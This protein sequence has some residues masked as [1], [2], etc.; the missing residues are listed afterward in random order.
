MKSLIEGENNN[1]IDNVD[2][3]EAE[4]SAFDL[5]NQPPTS[6]CT[7][8]SSSISVKT[9]LDNVNQLK[10]MFPGRLSKDIENV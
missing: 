6:S 2:I 3:C 9:N 7:G 4:K 8:Q 10:E 1:K 5:N